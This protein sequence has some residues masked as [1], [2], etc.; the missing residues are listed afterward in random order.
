MR[1]ALYSDLHFEF[2]NNSYDWFFDHTASRPLADVVIFAGDILVVKNGLAFLETACTAYKN[3][4]YV[5]G[6]HEHYGADYQK[7]QMRLREFTADNFFY[8]ERDSVKIDGY[9]FYGATTWYPGRASPGCSIND[10]TQ[11]THSRVPFAQF[12]YGYHLASKGWLKQNVTEGSI[13]ITHMLPS[14]D[15]VSNPYKNN[16]SNCFYVADCDD[17]IHENKPALWL[18]GHSHQSFDGMIGETRVIRNPYGYDRAENPNFNP[19]IL[20]EV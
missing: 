8:L 10:F 7:T 11:I 15:C 3:V 20:I 14:Q 1:L 19:N 2:H 13:V 17:V 5:A 9:T 12:I 4:I 6:N 18:H 16:W